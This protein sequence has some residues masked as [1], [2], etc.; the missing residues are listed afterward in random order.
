MIPFSRPHLTGLELH[1]I[2]RTYLSSSLGEDGVFAVACEREIALALCK[3]SKVAL[4]TSIGSAYELLADIV[5]IGAHDEV[6][7]PALIHTSA[8]NAFAK[9]GARLRYY[10]FVAGGYDPNQDQLVEALSDK[11]RL[12]VL[13]HYLG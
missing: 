2:A 8:A 3:D 6:L 7:L 5:Q 10:D 9:R 4:T 1:N 13:T 11:T 12:V